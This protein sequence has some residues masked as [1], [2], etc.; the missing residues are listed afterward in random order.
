MRRSIW[1]V[2]ALGAVLVVAL[3]TPAQTPDVFG[4]QR[5]RPVPLGPLVQNSQYILLLEVEKASP[6]EIT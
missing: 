4:D 5:I 6:T 3:P 1:H 2:A